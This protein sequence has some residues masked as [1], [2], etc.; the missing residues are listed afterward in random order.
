MSVGHVEAMPMLYS[1]DRRCRQSLHKRQMFS[2]IAFMK[3]VFLQ[4]PVGREVYR[5]ER[6]VTEQASAS[7]LVQANETKLAHNV[8]CTLGDGTLCLGRLALNLKPDF[9]SED[10]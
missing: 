7:T 5:R 9:A 2:V 4:M 3:Y 8:H 1:R 10:C 6:D